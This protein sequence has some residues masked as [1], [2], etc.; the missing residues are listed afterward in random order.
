MTA[1]IPLCNKGIMQ[2]KTQQICN[3]HCD[4]ISITSRR[5]VSAVKLP[6]S[7]ESRTYLRYKESVHSIECSLS[8][9]LIYV[10]LSPD[11]G[12]FTAE[13]RRLDVIDILSQC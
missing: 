10:L 6:S 1:A 12:S 8:L 9:Y 5:H 13:T 7:G 4:K 11:D 3:Q 2:S